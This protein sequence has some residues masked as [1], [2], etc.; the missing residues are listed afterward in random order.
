MNRTCKT[1]GT[2]MTAPRWKRAASWPL[3]TVGIVFAIP[4]IGISLVATVYGVFLRDPECQPCL[5]ALRE[6]H[7]D[8]NLS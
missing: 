7:G 8:T 1:C 4:T 3:I 2:Q 5:R 6:A